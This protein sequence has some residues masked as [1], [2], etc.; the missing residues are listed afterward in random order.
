M[1]FSDLSLSPHAL[2]N[3]L[4]QTSTSQAQ[5]LQLLNQKPTTVRMYVHL[6]EIQGS[7][8]DSTGSVKFTTSS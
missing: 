2:D 5:S 6:Y 1:K 4:S 8:I 3:K 7:Y